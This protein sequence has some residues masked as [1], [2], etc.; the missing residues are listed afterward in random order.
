MRLYHISSN[1]LHGKILKPQI[2]DNVFVKLGVENNT[3]KRISFAPTVDYALL[4]TE[5]NKLKLGPNILD[6]FEPE[7]YS[8]IKLTLSKYLAMRG[9]VP[10]ANKTREHWILNPVKVIY[11][12][13]IKLLKR[14]DKFIETVVNDIHIIRNYYWNYEILDGEL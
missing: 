4:V 12:G 14:K 3:L 13:Q 2:P 10:Q 11:A 5:L 6:V 9:L 1:K 8:K 7:D